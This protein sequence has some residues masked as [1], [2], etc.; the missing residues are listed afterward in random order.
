MMGTY[1]TY[2]YFSED[3]PEEGIEE[4][5][6]KRYAFGVRRRFG[7]GRLVGPEN[8]FLK[9]PRPTT[10][11]FEVHRDSGRRRAAGSAGHEDLASENGAMEP[12]DQARFRPFDARASCR[13]ST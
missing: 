9:T 13:P 4:G 2:Q 11:E 7:E 5:G 10:I 6:G 8:S 1:G 12:L 3:A